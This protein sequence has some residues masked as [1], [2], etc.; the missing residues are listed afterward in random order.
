MVL[1]N[2]LLKKIEGFKQF[3][4]NMIPIAGNH[5]PSSDTTN[6]SSGT[7]MDYARSDHTHP[8]SNL[9]AES[10]HT[11]SQYLTTHQDISGKLNI[12]QSNANKGKNVVVNSSTGNIDF[13]DKNNHSHGNITSTGVLNVGGTNQNSKP[14]ITDSNGV[15]IGGAFGTSSGQFAEGNHTHSYSNITGVSTMTVTITYTDS[16]PDETVTLLKY[17][18]S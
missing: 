17:T 18:S 12:S 2:V 5:T 6:G 3:V 15:I 13:E 16:T 8:K 9:Y 10:V 14:V 4:A 7:N 11:H 1:N